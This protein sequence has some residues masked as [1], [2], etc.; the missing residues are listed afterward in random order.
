MWS[1]INIIFKIPVGTIQKINVRIYPQIPDISGIF[2]K[3]IRDASAGNRTR[4]FCMAS[5][6]F[7]TKPL[8]HSEE[9]VFCIYISSNTIIGPDWGAFGNFHNFSYK[10][11]ISAI[12]ELA[13]QINNS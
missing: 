10:N 12:T 13:E 2:E 7:T 5:R 11:P 1:A 6:N 4:G 8:T 3:K 9:S